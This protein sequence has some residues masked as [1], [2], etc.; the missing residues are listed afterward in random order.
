MGKSGTPLRQRKGPAPNDADEDEDDLLSEAVADAS[1]QGSRQWWLG[2]I[3][4]LVVVNCFLGYVHMQRKGKSKPVAGQD[5][6]GKSFED[7]FSGYKTIKSFSDESLSAHIAG[8]P[9]G[10]LVNFRSS[11]CSHCKKLA[12]EFETASK[13]LQRI[14]DTSFVSVDAALVPEALK[15]YSVTRYPTLLWF[16]RG[17]LLKVAPAAARTASKIVDFVDQSLQPSV[18]D[19]ASRDDFD[20]AV[21]QLRAVLSEES[22]PVVVGFASGPEVYDALQQAAEKFRGST[23]FLFVREARPDDPYVR[24]YSWKAGGDK[25]YKSALAMQD[26]HKWLQPL[27]ERNTKR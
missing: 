6:S 3:V 7:E 4:L 5:V 24:A 25:E 13:E 26:F 23:A 18:I 20:K 8:H 27:M 12:P 16:R 10:T 14:Y 9:N 22:L 1:S 17:E 21:E 2:V 11:D 19:F 15:R